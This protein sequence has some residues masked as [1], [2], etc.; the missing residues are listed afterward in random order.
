MRAVESLDPL[1]SSSYLGFHEQMNTSL[2]CP[3]NIV[4]SSLRTTVVFLTTPEEEE[5]DES[6]AFFSMRARLRTAYGISKA[7]GSGM[8]RL[9]PSSFKCASI[10]TY[11]RPF[12]K[13][14]MRA[15]GGKS[16][17]VTADFV[18]KLSYANVNE[19]CVKPDS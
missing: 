17:A 16:E 2:E 5:D 7:N 18:T 14:E 12:C 1:A 15:P 19:E 11:W 4:T 3:L 9:V 13:R 10:S 6:P 8:S